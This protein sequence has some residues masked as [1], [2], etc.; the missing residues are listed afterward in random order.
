M[1]PLEAKSGKKWCLCAKSKWPHLQAS[2]REY[3]KKKLD[4]KFQTIIAHTRGEIKEF[5][6]M[7]F[8]ERKLSKMYEK[9]GHRV[10]IWPGPWGERNPL[11][12]LALSPRLTPMH[13]E[14]MRCHLEDG[15]ST[16]NT[17]ESLK[18]WQNNTWKWEDN[19]VAMW[20]FKVNTWRR[21]RS[22]VRWEELPVGRARWRMAWVQEQR[23]QSIEWRGHCTMCDLSK[24]ARS[25]SQQFFRIEKTLSAHFKHCDCVNSQLRS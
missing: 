24:G 8:S 23:K 5:K 19:G 6:I 9:E 13:T 25:P 17:W 20:S 10:R 1:H 18:R 3:L 11:Q 16:W 2:C 4:W 21:Q 22:M 15:A 14:S 12:T 7:C